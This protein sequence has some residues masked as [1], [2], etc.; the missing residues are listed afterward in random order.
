MNCFWEELYHST[1][2]I[3]YL[4]DL[5][6]LLVVCRSAEGAIGQGFIYDMTTKGWIRILDLKASNQYMTNIVLNPYNNKLMWGRHTDTT[7][8]F[9][10]YQWDHSVK[11]GLS[12]VYRTKDKERKTIPSSKRMDR[13]FK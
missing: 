7:G 9:N 13:R 10:F 5:R 1:A 3:S 4:P 12:F 6:Q 8:V 11:S 2:Q